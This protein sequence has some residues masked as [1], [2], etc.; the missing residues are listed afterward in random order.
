L[1]LLWQHGTSAAPDAAEI[2]RLAGLASMKRFDRSIFRRNFGEYSAGLVLLFYFGWNLSA[3]RSVAFSLVASVCVLVVLGSLCWQ[4]RNLR[5]LDPSADARAFHAAML[6]RIDKQL[7][8]LGHRF[9]Y[10]MPLCIPFFWGI[11]SDTNDSSSGWVR[12]LAVLAAL[13]AAAAWLNENWGV[14]RLR[15]ERAKIERLYEE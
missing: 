5:L 10:L 7:L 11:L 1:T 13:F 9:W 2:S 6:A 12:D 15:E 4:H 14:R 8:L 3:G